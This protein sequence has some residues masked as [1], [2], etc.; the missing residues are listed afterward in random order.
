MAACG[1]YNAVID[2]SARHDRLRISPEPRSLR[3]VHDAFGNYIGIARFSGRSSQIIQA[4]NT[5]KGLR[6]HNQDSGRCGQSIQ[7]SEDQATPDRP[8]MR[9][10]SDPHL[11]RV[12]LVLA[13]FVAFGKLT[14]GRNNSWQRSYASGFRGAA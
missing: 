12:V 14:L 8:R 3:F 10:S 6:L 9:G 4:L 11:D 2:H 1:G 5:A 13:H 7:P